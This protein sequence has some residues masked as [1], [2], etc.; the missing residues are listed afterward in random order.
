MS[1][2]NNQKDVKL[3]PLTEKSQLPNLGVAKLAIA[4]PVMVNFAFN[5]YSGYLS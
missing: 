5:S 4:V 3:I 1:M 2:R